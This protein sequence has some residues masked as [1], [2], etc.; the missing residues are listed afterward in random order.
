MSNE[1]ELLRRA[2]QFHLA[3][4]F[5]QA[6]QI[7]RRILGSRPN[8]PAAL[9]GLAVLNSQ[10]GNDAEAVQWI[11]RAVVSDPQN[12]KFHF[13]CG[14]LRVR[15]GKLDAAIGS[16][17]QALSLKPDYAEA[18]NELGNVW[19]AQG[20]QEQAIASYRQSLQIQP[21]SAMLRVNL[22]IALH[23][24]GEVSQAIVEYQSAIRIQPDVAEYHHYLGNAYGDL[25]Q[26]DASIAAY[27]NAI[28][29]RPDYVDPQNNLGNVYKE[30]RQ[31]S[32]AVAAYQTVL[33][34]KP[35]SA[36]TYFNLG[37][38]FQ[39]LG[40][41]HEALEA[42]RQSLR[43]EPGFTVVTTAL[44]ALQQSL[45]NWE[46]VKELTNS[47]IESVENDTPKSAAQLVTPF[48]F[49]CLPRP[50]TAKQQWRCTRQWVSARFSSSYLAHANRYASKLRSPH[51]RLRIGYLSADFHSHATTSLIAE[52]IQAHDRQ[53]FEVYGYSYG[54]DD[55]SPSRQ[56][57][58]A[59]FDFFRD[60]ARQS[61]VETADLIAADEIDILIDLKGYTHQS[62]TEILTFRP[63]PIQVNFLGYPG[64]MGAEF[65]DYILV[66]DFIAPAEDQPF[67]T[68]QL[69]HLPSC[70][71][72]NDSRLPVASHTPTRSECGLPDDGFVFC[73]F[74]NLYKITSDVFDVWMKLLQSVPGSVLWLL[75][76]DPVAKNNLKREAE[77]RGVSRD[78]LVFVAKQPH[79]EHLA[80][81]RWIDLFLDTFPVNAHT[82]AS[83]ALRMGVPMV[84]LAGPSFISRVAGSLLRAVGMKELIASDLK[85]YEQI[86]MRLACDPVAL[87][88]VRDKLA[89]NLKSNP[90]YN[91]QIF[92]R[93]IEHE[94]C[95]MWD[96]YSSNAS[97]AAKVT[98]ASDPSSSRTEQKLN[99]AIQLHQAGKLDE[100]ER[101][102]REVLNQDVNH[103]LAWYLLGIIQSDRG[104]PIAAID[105]YRR[106]LSI[107]RDF[108]EAYNNLGSALR[109]TG[110]SSEAE[111]AYREAIRRRDTFAESHCNLG[112][113]LHELG[114][115]D[116]A[117]A[118]YQRA[119]AL[120]PKMAEAHY[121]LGLLFQQQGS[122]DKA[123]EAFRHAIE[124]RPKFAEAHNNLGN[125]YRDLGDLNDA[126]RSYE[127]ALIGRPGYSEAMYNLG[128]L[129]D[130]QGDKQKAAE[131][132]LQLLHLDPSC[133]AA[134][135]SLVRIR[136]ELFDWDRLEELSRQISDQL[137]SNVSLES[138]AWIPPLNW[139]TLPTPLSPSR[140]LSCAQIWA[141]RFK[142]ASSIDRRSRSSIPNP[143]EPTKLRIGYLSGDF[144]MHPV[145][146]LIGDLIES[147][148]RTQFEVFGYASNRSDGSELALRIQNAF[149][150]F[151]QLDNMSDDESAHRIA[152]DHIDILVDL[153]GYTHGA[154][155]E[156][157]MR[158]PAPI[159][160]NYLGYPCTMGNRCIDYIL[161]DE[162]VAP[163]SH[164]PFYSEKR[165]QL[166]GCFMVNDRFR[167]IALQTPS[168]GEAG[169]PEQGLV[170]CGFS[171]SFKIT[172]TIFRV[173]MKL[174][175]ATPGSVLWLR[176]EDPASIDNLR[177][178]A[179][180]SG[181]S[182]DRLVFAP[183][184]SMPEH[185]ARHRLADLFLDTFPYNQHS[186]ASD[187]LR[188]GV[189]LLTLVGETLASRVAGS[190]LKAIGLPELMTYSIAEY[191]TVAKRLANDATLLSSLRSRLTENLKNHRLFDGRAFAKTLEQAFRSMWVIHQRG[192]SPKSIVVAREM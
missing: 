151:C 100:A 28:K 112:L 137:E 69:V 79:P 150:H 182:E 57:I 76:I 38:T 156:I 36:E 35:D 145:G 176:A 177:R 58:T 41:L 7:Y 45:A 157:L 85:M 105:S 44:V 167:K 66:D 120:Q 19:R 26:F 166:P 140:L 50:T 53:Q 72:V 110:R 164:Q 191:E 31:L 60:V 55:G 117:I 119:M 131:V 83:D 54:P 190:L 93:R 25:G 171:S 101:H 18:L 116:V 109:A 115:Y 133:I 152:N 179:K 168:R 23:E 130:A 80:R 165:V 153:Q 126:R 113:T 17:L 14:L 104:D 148:D 128:Q 33:Q 134:S 1:S 94:Y 59:S 48:H 51:N 70:Y 96:R 189:P 46:N 122:N 114:Q 86:A 2:T 90:L 71:Q 106:S 12:A 107:N 78:R 37:N 87:A 97:S 88:A 141:S 42:Y 159:Q 21:N 174:L 29:I 136:Q 161:V 8:E 118:S 27:Q 155:T 16:F 52:M 56:R 139:L 108:V 184:V 181:V 32:A 135:V 121:N 127:L 185:L 173:W 186:T 89:H 82:T 158:R 68:E 187:A 154:R 81:H 132:F 170:F 22:G 149:D 9:H 4:Q 146:Y 175:K 13:D 5:E 188:M 6:S 183:K 62:R 160:I 111:Q 77:V 138:L 143:S 129:L 34:L 43:I 178:F 30:T 102:Y 61:F 63:A 39:E 74:N 147:H 123:I 3:G 20:K 172:P 67:Y 95:R 192:E 84:T 65:V 91:G 125:L 11:E 162:F 142:I 40:Q 24:R 15:I 124:L 103:F 49:I 180:E 144:G 47:I 163:E 98:N 75:D 99:T 92:A 64:T 10:L 169:L 73:S